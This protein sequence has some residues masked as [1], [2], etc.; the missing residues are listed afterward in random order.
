ML[1]VSHYLILSCTGDCVALILHLFHIIAGV[2]ETHMTFLLD[3][4]FLNTVCRQHCGLD[5]ALHV[6]TGWDTGLSPLEMGK[7]IPFRKKS[8]NRLSH[9]TG[10]L[11]GHKNSYTSPHSIELSLEALAAPR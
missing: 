9:A 3:H 2:R 11:N 10:W 7:N 8:A 1:S 5:L 6:L 4:S